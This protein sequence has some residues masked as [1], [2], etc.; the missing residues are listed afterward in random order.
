MLGYYVLQSVF[1]GKKRKLHKLTFSSKIMSM[2]L[3]CHVCFLFASLVHV[4][5]SSD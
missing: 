3:G 2:D 4:Y 5:F 1:V